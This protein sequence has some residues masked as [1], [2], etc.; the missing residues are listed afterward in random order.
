MATH[1]TVEPATTD[2]GEQFTAVVDEDLTTVTVII[3]PIV[4]EALSGGLPP[5]VTVAQ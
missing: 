2:E 5:S 3:T 1:V 4:V